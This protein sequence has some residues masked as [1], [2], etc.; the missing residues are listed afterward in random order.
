M[1]DENERRRRRGRRRRCWK[2]EEAT[3]QT[4]A[5]LKKTFYCFCILLLDGKILIF[6]F[7]IYVT[8]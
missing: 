5:A 3:K 8:F 6:L 4:G 7:L 2:I 1:N